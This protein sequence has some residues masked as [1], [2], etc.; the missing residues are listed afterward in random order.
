MLRS[1]VI[2]QNDWPI[3]QCLLLIRV[4]FG[5]KTKSPCPLAGDKTN[6]ERLS[7][8]FFKVIQE[9]LCQQQNLGLEFE[10]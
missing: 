10:M 5:R 3:E 7:K 1:D 8:P 2:L 9:L 4:S 6:N